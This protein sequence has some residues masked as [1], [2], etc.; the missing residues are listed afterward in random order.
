[1]SLTGSG[2]GI[3][4]C[5]SEGQLVLGRGG[6][7]LQSHVPDKQ[8]HRQAPDE[9]PRPM[10]DPRRWSKRKRDEG[11]RREIPTENW[12]LTAQRSHSQTQQR[13]GKR[14]PLVVRR[15]KDPELFLLQLGS[16]LWRGS[17]PRP[18]TLCKPW[19]RPNIYTCFLIFTFT[20]YIYKYNIIYKR[21]TLA[22]WR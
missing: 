14:R 16:L 4:T 9:Q 11:V 13:R 20:Y 8:T 21:A 15:D 7:P 5:P 17:D 6:T 10:R 3:L 2:D 19:A 22:F 12:R 1:M 18:G